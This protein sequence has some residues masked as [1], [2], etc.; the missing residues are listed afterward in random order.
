MDASD[1]GVERT[2]TQIWDWI[3]DETD[4]F[5]GDP[6]HGYQMDPERFFFENKTEWYRCRKCQRLHYR[7]SSLPCPYPKC[8]GEIE[9]VDIEEEQKNNYFYHL[10]QDELIPIRVEEHTA[11]LD[12]TRGHKYQDEFKK[13]YINALSCSTPSRWA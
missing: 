3:L 1:E 4:L 6:T 11:Q 7:G 13:G 12:S 10:F 9:A 5:I 8:G 2:L